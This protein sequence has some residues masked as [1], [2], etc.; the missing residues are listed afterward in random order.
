MRPLVC[1]AAALCCCS[2]LVPLAAHATELDVTVAHFPDSGAPVADPPYRYQLI[3]GDPV[4]FKQEGTRTVVTGPDKE[5]LYA[6]LELRP[7]TADQSLA[8]GRVVIGIAYGDESTLSI[9]LLLTKSDPSKK[10]AQ[11]LIADSRLIQGANDVSSKSLFL[12]HQRARILLESRFAEID[13]GL[14]SYNGYDLTAA[15]VYLQTFQR[16]FNRVALQPDDFVNRVSEFLLNAQQSDP[17]MLEDVL[18]RQASLDIAPLARNLRALPVVTYQTLYDRVLSDTSQDL[19]ERCARFRKLQTYAMRFNPSAE[20]VDAK[21]WE[22]LAQS[23]RS[24]VTQCMAKTLGPAPTPEQIEAARDQLQGNNA[25][26]ASFKSI[27]P[28][29]LAARNRELDAAIRTASRPL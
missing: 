27:K 26:I 23:A 14:R 15:F 20:A 19:E 28:D 12:I 6:R 22:R 8:K 25:V 24:A 3:D 17:A 10:A 7:E 16:L 29:E 5:F 1:F 21:A 18:G 11:Q 9:P 4:Q 2:W 13:Q